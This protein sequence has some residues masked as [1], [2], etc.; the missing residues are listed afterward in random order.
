[1]S[2]GVWSQGRWKGKGAL[3]FNG[4]SAYV[5]C[6]NASLT[7]ADITIEAWVN[8]STFK[9]WCGI[10]SNMTAWGTGF[11]LQIGTSKRIAAMVSGAYLTTN[12][13]PETGVWYHIAA[14]HDATTNLNILYVNGVEE[15]RVTKAVIYEANP[16]TCIG[17][18]YT[19]NTSGTYNFNGSID[20]VAIY[21]RALTGKEIKNH[22]EMGRP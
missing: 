11:G 7:P 20:E 3:L 8:A 21:N 1:I 18:F 4:T 9:S 12:W 5:D 13:T 17:L 16:K 19:S 22:Y 14:T 10:V 15:N 2:A 6:G